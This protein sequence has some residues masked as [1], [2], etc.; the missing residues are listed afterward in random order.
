M[1]LYNFDKVIERKNTSSLKYD[2]VNDRF[3]ANDIFLPMWVADMD[4]QAPSYIQ[5]VLKK[6]IEH[7]IYGYPY[8]N[9]N[10]FKSV[11]KWINS[12]YDWNLTEKNMTLS[13]TVVISL[14][15]AV[16]AFSNEGDEVIIQTPVYGPFYS[17]IKD[18]N[19]VIAENPLIN[20]DGYY[21][22]DL[23]HFES[24]ITPKTKVLLLCSPH[25]PVGRVWKK[26][27]LEKLANICLKHD[28]KIISDEIHSDIIYSK[29]T[30]IAKLSKEI[31]MQSMIFNSPG[32]TFNLSGLYI[33]YAYT[34]NLKMLEA[35]NDVLQKHMSS[36]GNILSLEAFEVAYD[37]AE[38][39]TSELTS[40]LQS[41]ID[42]AIDYLNKHLP[43]IKVCKPEGT[44]LL[45]L[46]CRALGLSHEDI[47]NK[48][49]KKGKIVLNSGLDF[50]KNGEGFFRLNVALP[51][52]LLEKGLSCIV[53]AL[54]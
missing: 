48:L 27:E 50:G 5:D 15:A 4:F 24:I 14:A 51:K 36:I 8:T 22:M 47:F 18:Q 12:K 23:E 17:V 11:L 42:F 29:H 33:S 26:E 6:R 13:P 2:G 7:G 53:K 31:S 46:D 44:Y 52:S 25:N 43:D 54:S 45:W 10:L 41:N 39:W 1:S 30:P 34:E 20:N 3:G 38:T 49:I 28:I 40:Y 19:R 37:G 21:T 32:K 35:F 16:E 9:E